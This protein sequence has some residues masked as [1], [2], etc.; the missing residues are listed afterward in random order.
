MWMWPSAAEYEKVH[1]QDIRSQQDERRWNLDFDHRVFIREL[2]Q[3]GWNDIE[4][5]GHR[6]H[7]RAAESRQHADCGHDRRVTTEFLNDEWEP[8]SRGH[9][10][11]GGERVSH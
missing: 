9:H 1:Q 3:S 5:R 10:G 2:E 7:Q 8:Y 11:K 6:S 4:V